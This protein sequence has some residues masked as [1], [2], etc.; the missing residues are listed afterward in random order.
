MKAD[1]SYIICEA[2]YAVK[3]NILNVLKIF[4][5]IPGGWEGRD[6][7]EFSSLVSGIDWCV[8]IL[9]LEEKGK[10][11]YLNDELLQVFFTGRTAVCT[12]SITTVETKARY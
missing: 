9:M 4:N 5:M 2:L 3:V 10:G 7:C 6:I 11:T 12:F 1:E 8:S